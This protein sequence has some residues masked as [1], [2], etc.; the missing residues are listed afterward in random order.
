MAEQ[1]TLIQANT[2]AFPRQAG[3]LQPPC[4]STIISPE[5]DWEV[6]NGGVTPDVEVELSPKA[7]S[8]GHDP[9]LETAVTLVLAALEAQPLRPVP[10]PAP[11]RR[12]VRK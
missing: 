6:E 9:Q 5:G 12:A 7:V 3:V 1:P 10:R 11:A 8:E 2:A 4:P